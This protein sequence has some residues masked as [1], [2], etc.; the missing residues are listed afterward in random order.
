MNRLFRQVWLLQM[1]GM[2]IEGFRN[3]F[4]DRAEAQVKT[5]LALEAVAAAE[6]FE[7]SAEDIEAE[8]G[9]M[10]EMY[11][12]SVEDLKKYM[13]EEAVKEDMLKAKAVELIK[14]TAVKVEPKAEEAA[15]D[16]E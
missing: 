16:A 11:K 8:Y 9:K 5:T 10:A 12:A 7:V 6:N 14:E 4:R 2:D 13:S 15:E 1:S 3:T